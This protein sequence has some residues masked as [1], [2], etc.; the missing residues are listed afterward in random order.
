MWFYI[1]NGEGGF[2]K[3]QQFV[4]FSKIKNIHNSRVDGFFKVFSFFLLPID[5]ERDLGTV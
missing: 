4:V 1:N 2:F 3:R 5:V